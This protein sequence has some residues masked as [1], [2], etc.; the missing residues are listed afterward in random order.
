MKNPSNIEIYRI[1][2]VFFNEFT[3]RLNLIAHK[4]GKDLITRHRVFDIH[5]EKRSLFGVH[6]GF[7][8]LFRVHFTKTFVAFSLCAVSKLGEVQENA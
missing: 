4:D 1:F 3:A 8:K 2:C 5:A 7:P 6:G